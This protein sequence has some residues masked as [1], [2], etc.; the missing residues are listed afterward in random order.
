[1]RGRCY[2]LIR[3]GVTGDLG[4]VGVSWDVVVGRIL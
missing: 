2:M 3:I 1:M 4:V